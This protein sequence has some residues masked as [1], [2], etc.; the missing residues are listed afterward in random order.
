M[1]YLYSLGQYST[2][3]P[4]QNNKTREGKEGSW[5]LFADGLTLY[6]DPT[7]SIQT[8]KTQFLLISEDSKI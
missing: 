8:F 3:I 6:L 7:V 2:R 4:S 1:P 5:S